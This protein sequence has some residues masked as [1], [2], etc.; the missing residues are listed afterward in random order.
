MLFVITL[1]V[2]VERIHHAG[3]SL[4]FQILTGHFPL[5]KAVDSRKG[6]VRFM[7]LAQ[8]TSNV[9]FE[10]PFRNIH[11][12]TFFAFRHNTRN[13]VTRNVS[14]TA[15]ALKSGR[16]EPEISLVTLVKSN[17]H[18]RNLAFRIEIRDE[19]SWFWA[20]GKSLSILLIESRNSLKR[21]TSLFEFSKDT[22][23]AFRYGTI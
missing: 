11:D 1:S 5:V 23:P 14:G 13:T 17:L 7:A 21:N 10:C 4:R 8:L 18:P 15:S 20:G 2:R 22:Y 16:R 3:N 6:Y 9:S 19:E 12:L